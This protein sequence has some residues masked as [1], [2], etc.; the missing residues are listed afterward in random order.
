[1]AGLREWGVQFSAEGLGLW[2]GTILSIPGMVR[3][4]ETYCGTVDAYNALAGTFGWARAQEARPEGPL[5]PSADLR[6][7]QREAARWLTS[8]GGGG[9]LALPCQTG[10]TRTVLEAL[11]TLDVARTVIVGPATAGLQWAGQAADYLGWETFLLEGRGG[12]SGRVLCLG[13]RGE[14]RAC[15]LCRGLNGASL[16]YR[17]ARDAQA[18]LAEMARCRLTYVSYDALYAHRG[19]TDTDIGYARAD[20]PGALPALLAQGR[21]FWGAVV[22]DEAHRLRGR[23]QKKKGSLSPVKRVEAFRVL[24]GHDGLLP[25]GADA[26][27]YGPPAER[28]IFTTGTPQYGRVRD[29]WSLLDLLT[30]GKWGDAYTFDRRYCQGAFTERGWDNKGASALA[31]TELSWRLKRYMWRRDREDILPDMPVKQRVTRWVTPPA[32]LVAQRLDDLA[33]FDEEALDDAPEAALSAAERGAFEKQSRETLSEKLPQVLD[34]VAEACQEGQRVMVFCFH[35]EAARRFSREVQKL[36]TRRPESGGWASKDEPRVWTVD[37][38]VAPRSRVAMAAAFSNLPAG[39]G[40]VLVSTIDALQEAVTI[41]G[42]NTVHFAELHHNPKA[43]G[44]AEDRGYQ[45]DSRGLV[46]VYWAARGTF[47]EKMVRKLVDK[48]EQARDVLE[49]RDADHMAKSLR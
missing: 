14:G 3:R 34:A 30:G 4:G 29:N 5:R 42:I 16:G 45:P 24:A 13:C 49:D 43:I 2:E 17:L 26:D 9:I 41:R 21:G 37:G 19:E 48:S 25:V 22:A 35:K 28:V 8:E 11:A 31:T 7:Y 44:Q 39:L 1:M 40:A 36:A 46:V 47:D 32:K 18:A 15:D 6:P 27:V 12:D 23:A 10:K 20:L 33:L 38:S